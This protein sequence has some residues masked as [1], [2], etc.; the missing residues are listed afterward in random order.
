MTHGLRIDR[1]LAPNP[2]PYTG[3]GTNTWVVGD[4]RTAIVLDPGPVVVSHGD[5]ILAAVGDRNVSAVIVTHTHVDHAPLAN[6]LSIDVA[7]PAI[8]YAPGPDFEPDVRVGDGS[9]IDVA[10]RQ[11]IVVHTPGHSDDHLCFRLEDSLFTGDHIMG[12][13]SVMV[14]DM[15]PYLA[16]LERIHHTGLDRL[17]PGHGDEMD[18]PDDVISWYLAHR[19]ERERQ[20]VDAIAGGAGSIGAVVETVYADV[21]TALHP[22][23]A[24]SVVAHLRKLESEGRARRSGD[25]WG[26]SVAL[27]LSGD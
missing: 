12:G 2:G 8:G 21:D 7:A 5:A 4:D 23:A 14:E 22:L 27:I 17:Y 3:P 11:L 18:R 9:V 15:G 13:S 19:L 24:R 20:I 25:E 26:D 10:G 1:V 6:P 16:S